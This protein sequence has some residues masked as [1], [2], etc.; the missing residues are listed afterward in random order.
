[1]ASKKPIDLLLTN[2]TLPVEGDYVFVRPIVE[3]INELIREVNGD[4]PKGKY[5][6][7][8]R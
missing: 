5:Q 1:M 8:G 7:R 6:K 3:K 4:I 2:E